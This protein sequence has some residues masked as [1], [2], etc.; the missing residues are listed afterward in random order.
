MIDI[1]NK[2]YKAISNIFVKTIED[3]DFV[4]PSPISVYAIIEDEQKNLINKIDFKFSSYQDSILT[5]DV[6]FSIFAYLLT[7]D[8]KIEILHIANLTKESVQQD[9][10]G[11]KGTYKYLNEDVSM[12]IGLD[13]IYDLYRKVK[14]DI[15]VYEEVNT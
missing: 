13:E 15:I 4:F 11:Y 14:K 5:L 10:H 12:N 3:D 6:Y 8:Y 7:F 9:M 2:K 1:F